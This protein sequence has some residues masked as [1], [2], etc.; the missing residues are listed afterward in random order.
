MLGEGFFAHQAVAADGINKFV[1][2]LAHKKPH[3][4]PKAKSVSFLYMYAGPSHIDTFDYNPA[5]VG[6]DGKTIAAKTVRRGGPISGAKNWSSGYMPAQYE[7]TILRSSG[8]PILDLNRPAN[9]TDA[10][11][12]DMLD[13]LRQYNDEHVA[14]NGGSA[15][16]ASRIAAYELAYKK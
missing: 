6:M 1:N 2:P 16:L 10:A 7:G 14:R 11:Q 12:R 3:F 5:N 8:T 4:A 9:L 13:T 15:A